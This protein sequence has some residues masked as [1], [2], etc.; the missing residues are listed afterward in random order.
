[1]SDNV[2]SVNWACRRSLEMSCSRSLEMSGSKDGLDFYERTPMTRQTRR[3]RS[4]KSATSSASSEA[5]FVA[6]IDLAVD[7]G[8]SVV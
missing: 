8:L 6:G 3:G 7:G 4:T 2:Y 5:S 1:M